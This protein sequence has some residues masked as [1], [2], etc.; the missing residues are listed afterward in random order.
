MC[1]ESY[2]SNYRQTI[3]FANKTSPSSSITSSALCEQDTLRIKLHRRQQQL[4]AASTHTPLTGL[5]S[6]HGHGCTQ[7]FSYVFACTIS[8]WLPSCLPPHVPIRSLP[9]PFFV[10]HLS[11][12]SSTVN[13]TTQFFAAVTCPTHSKLNRARAPSAQVCIIE[14]SKPITHTR[15][16]MHPL[17]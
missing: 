15:Y 8:Y 6:V 17:R 1:K 7:V 4:R 10:H 13:P 2:N 12:S 14:T 11:P 9:V 3:L 16:G 5:Q